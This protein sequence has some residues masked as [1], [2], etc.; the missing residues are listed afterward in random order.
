MTSNNL[1]SKMF[2]K[3]KGDKIY[4]KIKELAL[5]KSMGYLV[6]GEAE[7]MS[8]SLGPRYTK[9]NSKKDQLRTNVLTNTYFF[10]PLQHS[11]GPCM[12]FHKTTKILLYCFNSFIQQTLMEDW[13]SGCQILLFHLVDWICPQS[14]FSS[15]MNVPPHSQRLYFV[16][17]LEKSG[18]IISHING[19]D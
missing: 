10:H 6:G 11:L 18:Q 14:L 17:L 13:I 1:K 15:S 3:D 7:Y 4:Q 9:R 12:H 19:E 16:S 2:F 8:S 5:Q